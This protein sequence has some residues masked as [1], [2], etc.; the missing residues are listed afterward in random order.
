V[1]SGYVGQLVGREPQSP[2]KS[3]FKVQGCRFKIR[4]TR[5]QRTEVGGRRRKKLIAD[6][7]WLIG[8]KNFKFNIPDSKLKGRRSVI[9]GRKSI[10]I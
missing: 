1:I 2:S 5:G 3:G 10:W 8:G 4:K 7:S 6:S 9:K